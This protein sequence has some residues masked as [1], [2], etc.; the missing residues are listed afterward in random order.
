MKLKRYLRNLWL[1]LM[2]WNPYQVELA[3]TKRHLD[4]AKVDAHRWTD[5]AKKATD[6]LV[7]KE[8][9]V[10]NYQNLTENLR[11]R[12][13]DKDIEIDRRKRDYANAI[14]TLREQHRLEREELKQKNQNL[15]DDLDA[16]LEELQKVNHDMGREMMNTNLLAKTN[17][18]LN[19]LCQAMRSADVEKMK[20]VAEY[21]DWSNLLL[22]VA[23]LH[24]VVLRRNL[25]LEERL[26]H[27]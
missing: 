15:R 24:L 12:I 4:D 19:D 3:E 9:E 6:S 8:Q 16:T 26:N 10:K 17:A 1:A 22:Q 2:G 21:L 7:R 20:A 18:A 23:Q 13:T 25:E 5:V 27:K 14:D 11:Q